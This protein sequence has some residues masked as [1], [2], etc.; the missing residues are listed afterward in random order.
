LLLLEL[1]FDG[2]MFVDCIKIFL[3]DPTRAK[4]LHRINR[5]WYKSEEKKLLFWFL[6][7]NFTGRRLK[8]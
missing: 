6:Y 5:P 7:A 1:A 3:A 8:L 4:E 2:G